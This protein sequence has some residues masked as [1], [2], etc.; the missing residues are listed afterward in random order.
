M[1]ARPEDKLFITMAL[2]EGP[3]TRGELLASGMPVRAYYAAIY[4]LSRAG[5]IHS[6]R[7]RHEPARWYLRT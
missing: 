3:K 2:K 5:I 7:K 4:D 6:V 1:T